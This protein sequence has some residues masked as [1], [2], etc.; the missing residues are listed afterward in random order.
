MSAL[1]T[2]V[3]VIGLTR[4]S[5]VCHGEGSPDV[6]CSDDSS[7]GSTPR[8]DRRWNPYRACT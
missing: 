3:V 6:T 1:A 5:M 4:M 7:F 8:K 2:S